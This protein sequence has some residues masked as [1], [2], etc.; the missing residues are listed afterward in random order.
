MRI[1]KSP[2]VQHTYKIDFSQGELNCLLF[3]LDQITRAKDSP[4]DRLIK[5][6]DDFRTRDDFDSR[7]VYK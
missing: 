3:F 7:T 4:L 5:S 2:P 1:L 6:L